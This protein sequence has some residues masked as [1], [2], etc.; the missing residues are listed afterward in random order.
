MLPEKTK[1]CVTNSEAY[2]AENMVYTICKLNILAWNMLV[3]G[4]TLSYVFL[5]VKSE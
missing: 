2:S 5:K 4:C 3:V 1:V